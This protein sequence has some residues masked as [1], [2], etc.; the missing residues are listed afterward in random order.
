MAESEI[1]EP[2]T[3]EVK[4][5]RQ[6]LRSKNYTPSEVRNFPRD[7]LTYTGKIRNFF[8]VHH[9]L[10]I[11]DSEAINC[12]V[13]HF[14]EELPTFTM[15]KFEKLAISTEVR[16][17]VGMSIA[18]KYF[19]KMTITAKRMNIATTHLVLLV[20]MLIAETFEDNTEYE[21]SSITEKF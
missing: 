9:G 6:V 18:R 8:L 16:G 20:T 12:A 15:K 17:V 1:E 2:E 3:G 10:E 13:F 14:I 7:I 4:K 19:S 5:D 11:T 21:V